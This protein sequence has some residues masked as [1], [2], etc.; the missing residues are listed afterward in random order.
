MQIVSSISNVIL[1]NAVSLYNKAE[2]RE[3]GKN[4]GQ[5]K[6]I[7]ERMDHSTDVYKTYTKDIVKQEYPLS[8]FGNQYGYDMQHEIHDYMMEYYKGNVDEDQVSGYFE[9]CILR[10]IL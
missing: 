1:D 5:Q 4:A 7:F 10:I 6:D 8:P 9:S 2:M 3:E